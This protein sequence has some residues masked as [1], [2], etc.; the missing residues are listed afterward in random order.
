M[1]KY[2][3]IASLLLS[4][5]TLQIAAQQRFLVAGASSEKVAII[6]CESGKV[7][8]E[9]SNSEEAI[10]K[11]NSVA[12]SKEGYVAYSTIDAAKVRNADGELIFEY[13]VGANEEVQ[14]ISTTKSGYL[15]GICGSPIRIVEL[16]KRGEVTKELSFESG[17]ENKHH[18]FR[19]ITQ[20]KSGGYIIPLMKQSR[21]VELDK[22][23]EF[24]KEVKLEKSS[25]YVDI[26]SKGNWLASSGHAG[27]IYSIDGKSGEVTKIIEG[28][29]LSSGARVE[30]G[31]EVVELRN[32]NILLANWLGH[33]GDQSQPILVEMDRE[34]NVVWQMARPEG[35]TFASAVCPI[36]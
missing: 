28:K 23:G 19:Q 14:S 34:G 32:G 12:Y 4:S 31:A 36:Y 27:T 13:R 22:K 7:E 35:Y 16:N 30:F 8:W 21:I 10:N 15:L 5:L 24:V 1:K 11:G 2:T 18:Q 20:S 6:N 9:Y 29:E 25:F 26:D 33:N 17:I 3:I